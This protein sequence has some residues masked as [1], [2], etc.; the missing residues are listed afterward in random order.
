MALI[1][2]KGTA[3]A[4]FFSAR[5]IKK[6]IEFEEDLATKNADLVCYLDYT[7]SITRIAH[8]VK[9]M[10]RDYIGSTADAPYIQS[11]LETWLIE[12]VTTAAN[13]DDLTLLYYPF[14]AM[15]VSVVPKP[16]PFGW[17]SATVSVLP[18]IKF[19]GMDVELRLEAA[20]GGAAAA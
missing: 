12:Y 19:Q 10:V 9:R 18:H 13:P 14:K 6:P 1:H 3:D 2:C 4:T 20:L 15:S 16:G 11:M 7:L 8:Y 5:S 17:Y